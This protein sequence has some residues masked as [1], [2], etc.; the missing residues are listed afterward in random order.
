MTLTASVLDKYEFTKA[1]VSEV[2]DAYICAH[3][4][5]PEGVTAIFGPAVI[6]YPPSDV[7][8]G[9]PMATPEHPVSLSATQ[10]AIWQCPLLIFL[11]WTEP[12]GPEN[13]RSTSAVKEIKKRFWPDS[14]GQSQ[15]DPMA[16]ASTLGRQAQGRFG[17][18]QHA[19]TSVGL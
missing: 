18:V 3:A 4:T 12:G 6:A 5:S 11:G 1:L 14:I 7:L 19:D 15:S 8:T 9:S 10:H 13:A 2:L 16:V 17:T